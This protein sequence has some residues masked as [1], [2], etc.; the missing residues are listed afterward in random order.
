MRI[1][2]LQKQG[3][4][5]IHTRIDWYPTCKEK[6]KRRPNGWS[7]IMYNYVQHVFIHMSL[8]KQ[9]ANSCHV[10]LQCVWS[11]SLTNLV[12]AGKDVLED[13]EILRYHLPPSG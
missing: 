11:K 5:T 4:K 9:E 13:K 10:V 2:I 8:E 12:A 3:L 6:I 1:R 7:K